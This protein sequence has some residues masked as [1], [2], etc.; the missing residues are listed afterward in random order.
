[1]KNSINKFIDYL[2]YEKRYSENTIISYQSDLESFQSFM[3]VQYNFDSIKLIKH[4]HVRS[5]M[6]SMMQNNFSAKSVNRKISTLKSYFKYLKKIKELRINPMLKIV[7]PKIG[8][9]LP[10]YIREQNIEQLLSVEYA[11]LDSVQRRN[12]LIVEMLYLTGM[13]RTELI[14]LKVSDIDF[15]NKRIKVLGKG[16]KERLIPL[17]EVFL[18]RLKSFLSDRTELQ[19]DFLFLSDKGK[20]MYDKLVYNIVTA[21]LGSI[22]SS[23]KKSPHILR[24]SFATHLS[25]NGAE[26]NAIKELLGHANLSATQIYTHNSIEKLK[27]VYHRSHPNA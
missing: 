4:T 8:K 21:L 23:S 27:E 17:N 5:W 25:N 11:D 19:S 24:H 20:K 16:N 2:K 1:M 12:L 10:E 6:V 22:T 15:E 7:S 13:R 26:L 9:R 14:N 18:N 3:L